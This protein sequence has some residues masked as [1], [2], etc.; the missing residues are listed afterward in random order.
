MERILM[1]GAGKG[2][3]KKN[4]GAFYERLPRS[5]RGGVYLNRFER[6]TQKGVLWRSPGVAE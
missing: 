3:H 5:P 1:R 6:V 4:P 2:S